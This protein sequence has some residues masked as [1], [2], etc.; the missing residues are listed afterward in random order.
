MFQFL[1]GAIGRIKKNAASAGKVGF[2]FLYGAI[3]SFDG[4][5]A[6]NKNGGFNSYMVRLEGFSFTVADRGDKVSIPIWCD[7]K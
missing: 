3:G 2:Q 7:W 1:Y 4:V 5:G 6:R